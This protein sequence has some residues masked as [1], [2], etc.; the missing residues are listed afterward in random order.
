MDD[1]RTSFDL[2]SSRP[3]RHRAAVRAGVALLTLSVVAA[4]VL[5]TQLLPAR[6][7][8]AKA[9][10][11]PDSPTS[12]AGGGRSGKGVSKPTAARTT[13]TGVTPGPAGRRTTATPSTATPSTATP[14]GLGTGGTTPAGTGPLRVVEI[15][16]SLGVDLGEAMQSTWPPANVQLTMAARGDT[17]LANSGYYD[18]PAELAGLLTRTHP[19]VVIV[20]LGA[21]DLQSMVTGAAVLY[22]G[23]PAWNAQYAARVTSI[24]SESL[25][26]GARVLWVGEPA[27]ETA[28]LNAGMSRIDGIAQ[29]VV[30]RH[31]ERAA[32]LDSNSVLAPGGSFSFD[33]TGPTGSQVQVRTPDGVHLMAAGADLLAGAAAHALARYWGMHVTGP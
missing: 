13:G 28:F 18:W 3:R 9:G 15:G 14:T 17:G 23:T 5:A 11:P 31:P 19:Q 10:A 21:N 16:D 24:V 27:M 32:Y 12:V 4:S 30:A 25:R 6:P 7:T 2:G 29:R 20:L 33:V 22:D 1:D 8:H 26:A